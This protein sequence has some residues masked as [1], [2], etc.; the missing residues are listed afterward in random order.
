MATTIV[1][2][3]GSGAPTTN[4]LIAGE[5][6]VDLTNK[7][8]YTENSSGTVLELGTNPA[9]DVTFGDNT[10]A[11]FGA[12]SDLQIYH[13]G[14]NSYIN[15]SGVGDLKLGGNQLQLNNAAQTRNYIYAVDE[16]QVELKYNNALKLATTATGIDVTGSIVASGDLQLGS[17]AVASNINALGDVFVVNVDSNNNTGGTPNIQFKTSG[18]EKLRVSPSGIDVTGTVTADGAIGA[19]GVTPAVWSGTYRPIQA[20][21]QAI[22]GVS[23]QSLQTY[24]ARFD[25][26]WKYINTNFANYIEVTG[27]SYIWNTAPSGEAGDTITFTPRM[28]LDASGHAII[29]AGVTLGTAAGVYAAANTLDDYEEGTWT[30]TIGADGGDPTVGYDQNNGAYTKVGNLVTVYCT[31]ITS[32]A[33]GGSGHLTVD[34]LPFTVAAGQDGAVNLSF[35]YNWTTPPDGGACQA[36]TN[37][38]IFYSSISTNTTSTPADLTNGT[39]YFIFT[40]SYRAA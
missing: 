26:A 16:A 39:N 37:R 38:A 2:K 36:S 24:N 30:P 11:I 32:S 40:A 35:N 12:G 19:G 1:T 28:T 25:S 8:L 27:G 29:P 18:N 9:S 14:D 34:G 10:K 5:L 20:G 13:D 6:A 17:D 22:V 31:I 33:T 15:D 3:S 21:E 4:D 23:G 7:R